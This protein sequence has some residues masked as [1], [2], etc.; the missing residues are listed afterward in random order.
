MENML[1]E[2]VMNISWLPTI[3]GFIL[4]FILGSLWFSP[5]MFGTKWAEGSNVTLKDSDKMPMAAMVTQ[6]IGTFLLA[7]FI[8]ITASIEY[9]LTAIIAL[10][11]IIL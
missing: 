1:T 5:K 9:L 4:A 8:G 7:W 6:A 3:T 10:L 2:N 11:A